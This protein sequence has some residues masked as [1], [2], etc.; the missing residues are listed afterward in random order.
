MTPHAWPAAIALP[1]PF[2]TGIDPSV[3][4]WRAVRYAM[5][6]ATFY[7]TWLRVFEY[8]LEPLLR[9]SMG[10][11]IGRE[12]LWVTAIGRFRIWG[13]R[14]GAGSAADVVVGA[15]GHVTVLVAATVP[16]VLFHAA[17]AGGSEGRILPATRFLASVVMMSLFAVRLIVGEVEAR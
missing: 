6:L 5:C 12:V 4:H 16:A 14:G 2:R 9:R 13:L 15:L 3:D 17:F 7:V 1:G 8:R 10:R 11:L